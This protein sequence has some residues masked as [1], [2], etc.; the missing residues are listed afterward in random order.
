MKDNWEKHKE[1]SYV[2]Y[3]HNKQNIETQNEGYNSKLEFGTAGI[4]G[5]FG[6]GEGRLNKFTIGKVALGIAN[7]LNSQ[8]N[9]HQ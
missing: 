8:K 9:H 3:F 5:K 4:R 2:E 1:E 7:Y 6:L